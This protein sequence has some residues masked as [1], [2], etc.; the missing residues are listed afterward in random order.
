MYLCITSSLKINGIA[1]ILKEHI[2]SQCADDIIWELDIFR[3]P[4][5]EVYPTVFSIIY[6]IKFSAIYLLVPFS[7]PFPNLNHQV[8][9]PVTLKII[10]PISLSCTHP[11]IIPLL[12]NFKI[13]NIPRSGFYI[14]Y[15][16]Q[17]FHCHF[18]VVLE[19]CFSNYGSQPVVGHKTNVVSLKS[20]LFFKKRNRIENIRIH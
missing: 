4:D 12:Q 10:Y 11:N 17:F 18:D 16:Q 3:S 8:W 15:I 20:H 6:Q 9:S 14:K 5:S 13:L 7:C 1:L 2:V 19:Q